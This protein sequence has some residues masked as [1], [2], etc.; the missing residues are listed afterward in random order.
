MPSDNGPQ[1]GLV[2]GFDLI[3]GATNQ[4]W[5]VVPSQVAP[6]NA[7]CPAGVNVKAYVALTAEGKFDEALEVVRERIALPGVLGRICPRPCEEKCARARFDGAVAICALKRFLAD[8]E[9]RRGG[10]YPKRLTPTR[11]EKVAVIGSG[12]CGLTAAQD[13]ARSGFAVT[14]FERLTT[15]GGMLVAAIPSFRLPRD[16]LELE[17]DNILQIGI[18]MRTGVSVGRDITIDDLFGRGWD[19]VLI[20]A[21]A[22]SPIGLNVQGEQLAGVEDALSFLRSVNLDG[23]AHGGKNVIV[24]GGGDSAIDSARTA[25]RLGAGRVRIFYRRSRQ[26]MPARDYEVEAAKAEGVQLHFLAGP[27]R[28]VENQ[29]RVAGVEFVR[30]R[31]AEPDKSGRPRPVPIEGT[32]WVEECDMLIAALGQKP[33]LEFVQGQEGIEVSRWGTLVVDPESLMCSRPGLFAAG[34]VVSGPAT[35]VEAIAAGHHVAQAIQAYLTGRQNLASS[36]C[37]PF[38]PVPFEVVPEPSVEAKRVPVPERDPEKR[39]RSFDEVEDAYSASQA[40]QEA[41]RC[42]MCG[43]CLE[44][45]QCI[46]LCD[47]RYAV[48]SFQGAGLP[49]LVEPGTLIKCWRPALAESGQKLEGEVLLSAQDGAKQAKATIERITAHVDEALCIGCG[50]CEE[51]CQY[52]AVKVEYRIDASLIATVDSG[53]CRGCGACV[54]GCPTGAID[55]FHFSNEWLRNALESCADTVVLYCGWLRAAYPE[56][57]EKFRASLAKDACFVQV[58]CAGR[59]GASTLVWMLARSV[60]RVMIASCSNKLCRYGS[61]EALDRAVSLVKSLLELLG[62]NPDNVSIVSAETDFA[63]TAVQS[64]KEGWLSR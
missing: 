34:D 47:G 63:S 26:Q 51:S 55:Q 12:P 37:A 60:K 10:R 5:S 33:D 39:A 8:Y 9:L 15:P 42:L 11:P 36:S 19:A 4:R 35:A 52:S 17:I 21:G 29:G 22:H 43:S 44:C 3:L 49:G 31:L 62:L 16:I 38:L 30:M 56:A 27:R 45:R 59:V 32:E 20:A 23:K 58:P 1:E 14:I 48:L 2:S 64:G 25:L 41:S 40:M 6:C 53:L 28:I 50:I 7:A 57:F 18:E 61:S 24:I 13:L 54:A 46:N